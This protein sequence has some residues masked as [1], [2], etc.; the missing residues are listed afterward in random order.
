MSGHLL[1]HRPDAMA[2]RGQ[3]RI[4]MILSEQESMSQRQLQD[5]LR[6]QPG[7]M[8]EILTKLER[9]GLLTRERGEDRRGN[10]LRITEAGR[11]ATAGKP[12][13]RE[14]DLF[15]ALTQEQQEQLR[16]LLLP[17]LTD[18]I[19]RFDRRRNR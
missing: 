10:L 13:P 5:M 17:L 11:R 1:H 18:W 4:L 2:A 3:E 8:S 6:I 16:G 7:S 15:S 12:A 9:K 19:A 14:E